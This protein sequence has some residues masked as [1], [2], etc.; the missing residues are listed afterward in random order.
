MYHAKHPHALFCNRTLHLRGI[1]AIGYDMDYT[2]IHYHMRA[3]EARAYAY[4]QSGLA[5]KGWPVEDLAFDPDLAMQGLIV[6]TQLGN[7]VKADRFSYARRGFH[8]TTA[9]TEDEISDTYHLEPIDLH[10]RRWRFMNTLFSISEASMYMQLVDLFDKGALEG[11]EAKGGALTYESLYQTVRRTLDDA[12]VEGRLKAEIIEHPERFV[13]LDPDMPLTL[14]DQKKSGKK[15]LLI[16]NSEWS[17]AAPMLAYAFDR[18]LPGEATWRDVFDIAIVGARKPIFFTSPQSAF[19]IV[20]EDGLLREFRGPL[21]EGH[22]YV[23]ANAG[24]VEQSLGL[25]GEEILYVG[26]HVYADVK[27]S[28]AL[29]RWRTALILREL[30]EEVGALKAFGAKQAR[31]DHL[32]AQKEALEAEFSDVRLEALRNKEAYGPQTARPHEQ[33][34]GEMQELRARLVDL[35][36]EVNQLEAEYRALHNPNWGLLMRAGRDKSHLARQL[37]RNADVYTSRVSNLLHHTPYVVLRS[38]KA[39]LPHDYD[40]SLPTLTRQEAREQTSSRS[41]LRRESKAA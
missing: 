26:D 18:F 4:I 9:L 21:R 10:E 17:Y 3:W 12:H 36:V 38:Y 20:S 41:P 6:D 30:E 2:L 14:L 25:K 16:T 39:S 32:Y 31:L 11:I 1:K 13:D 23:G 40:S 33:L 34:E 22:V 28:K 24:L 29:L 19:E 8:G 35:D 27:M 15:V 7:V 5:A 37:E